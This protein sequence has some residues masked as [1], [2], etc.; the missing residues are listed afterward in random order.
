MI[1][2]DEK[3]TK[4]M[5]IMEIVEKKPEAAQIMTEAGMHCLGCMASKFESLEQGC[6]VHGL[7]DKKI[8]EMIKKINALEDKKE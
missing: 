1:M 5:G 7:D 4:D 8:N 2:T 6:Q 3:I